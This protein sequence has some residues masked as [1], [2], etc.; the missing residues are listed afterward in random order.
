MG[1]GQKQLDLQTELRKLKMQAD[2]YEH[3]MSGMPQNIADTWHKLIGHMREFYY[4]DETWDGNELTFCAEGE[5]LFKMILSPD[6]ILISF[7][8][9]DA[10]QEPTVLTEPDSVDEIVQLVKAKQFPTRVVP[11]DNMRI[12]LGGGRCDLCLYNIDTLK[13]GDR[14]VEMSLGFAKCYAI[15]ADF[16]SLDCSGNCENCTISGIGGGLPGLTADEVTHSLI[17]YWWIKSS[18]N[19]NCKE[20]SEM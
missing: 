6:K 12:S 1:P 19:K 20:N 11:S 16:T 13:L 3:L 5:A 18:H 2:A 10:A 4:M 8:G 15:D 14:R 17:A 9:S 7:P